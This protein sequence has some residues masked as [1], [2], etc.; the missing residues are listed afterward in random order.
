MKM[1]PMTFA[2][3][4]AT[5]A[6]AQEPAS[7]NGQGQQV[8]DT[9]AVQNVQANPTAPASAVSRK[10]S[11]TVR[12][13]APLGSIVSLD[14]V[15]ASPDSSGRW[16]ITTQVDSLVRASGAVELCLQA[17][18][19]KACSPL[20]PQGF[21]TLE[22]APLAMKIDTVIEKRDT[23]INVVSDSTLD[24]ATAARQ[25]VGAG[26]VK[27][28]GAG[29]TKTVVIK[30]KRRP[31]RQMGQERVTVQT[32]K[33]MPGLA[34]PD[35]IRA[36]QAL[37][38]VV[39]S[40]DFSTKIYVRGSSSDQNLVLFDN[41]VVYSP[42]HFGGL[43][44]SFLADATGG[45]DFYKGGFESKYGNRLASVL[46]VS[47]KT[48]GMDTDSGKALDTW[49]KGNAR[50]T[51]FGG[52]ASVEGHQGDFSWV[53]AGRRT[54]VGEALQ[55][56]RD[57]GASSIPD[58]GYYF[59]DQQGSM[60]WG[61]DGDS[62]RVSV[63]QGRDSLTIVPI[64]LEWGNLAVPLNVRKKILPG[65]AY[66]GSLAWS[67]FDQ[68]LKFSE[69]LTMV[70]EVKT[71]NTRHELV[72]D[73]PDGHQVTG[74]YEYNDF[75]VKFVQEVS[76]SGQRFEDNPETRLHAMYVQDRWVID[77][78]WTVVGGVRGYRYPTTGE[79]AFDPRAS[80]T[81]RPAPNWKTDLHL[82]YYHQYLTSIRFSSQEMPNEYWYPVKGDLPSTKQGLLALGV[83]RT[84]LTPLKLRM[85]GE[86]YWKNLK[87]FLVYYPN[88]TAS[89]QGNEKSQSDDQKIASALATAKGWAAGGE[90][91][92]AKEDGP[93]TGSVSYALGWSVLRQDPFTNS[94]GT[95]TFD[96]HWADWDQRQTFKLMLTGNWL[97]DGVNSFWKS[98]RKR[99]FLRSTLQA[100]F[101]SGL[102]LTGYDGYAQTHLIGQG[103]DDSQGAG[104]SDGV[105]DNTY[106]MNAFRNSERK[107]NYFRAD[108]TLLDVGKANSW[109]F[110]YTI[111]NVT[112]HD[113]VYTVNYNTAENPPKKKTTSQFPFLPFFLGAEVE[114]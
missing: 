62:V 114:F 25:A 8:K 19:Q 71:L 91:G 86:A 63:Y 58:I 9:A 82:G 93:L 56:A 97:G 33:Q 55:A 104:G 24:S 54:W 40:S 107:P 83:E 89:E 72:W 61:H 100:N 4:L 52:S 28:E 75:R 36:V 35:V 79:V 59:Y 16:S 51:T 77:P 23:V 18:T 113:N 38:G 6:L 5:L 78:R 15:S 74:G 60:V 43:F 49:F 53:Y 108:L 46:A 41:A 12:S 94:L 81:W 105:K 17:G 34:E 29:A 14:G 90:L 44:S 47:S 87:D 88:K 45:L 1:I 50:L 95:T 66:R 27:V 92:I 68:T 106:V 73:G 11:L 109:R 10:V 22:I 20:R 111:I 37:P 112:D 101:N 21:D 99:F 30:G 57:A 98:S 84:E 48:G 42:S 69:I 70:N 26:A 3:A 7:G 31:P 110:Y 80:L 96:P 76:I 85:T 65:L 32:I 103:Y 13:F 64:Y 2:G 67:D 39:Q 102:P